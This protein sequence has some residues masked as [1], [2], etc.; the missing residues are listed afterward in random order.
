MKLSEN[1]TDACINTGFFPGCIPEIFVFGNDL[2]VDVSAGKAISDG[3]F[4]NDDQ[5]KPLEYGSD[6]YK[7]I[8]RIMAKEFASVY[9]AE[10]KEHVENSKK[11]KKYV[12]TLSSDTEKGAERLDYYKNVLLRN[13]IDLDE[14]MN[15]KEFIVIGQEG[16]GFGMKTRV[17]E[18]YDD[19]IT[20]ITRGEN[21]E[22]I[23]DE[24]NRS[25]LDVGVVDMTGKGYSNNTKTGEKVVVAGKSRDVYNDQV[26]NS[27]ASG[28]YDVI[29]GNHRGHFG[30]N[31]FDFE[32]NVQNITN[33]NQKQYLVEKY[34]NGT[35]SFNDIDN[36]Y[37]G[38]N[39][40]MVDLRSVSSI[41]RNGNVIPH[42]QTNLNN[43][44]GYNG[45][46]GNLGCPVVYGN[47]FKQIQRRFNN[48]VYH[49]NQSGKLG[50]FYIYQ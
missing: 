34:N 31:L 4:G 6:E 9:E 5:A 24:A 15:E 39:G 30:F 1:Y 36:E 47:D 28:E 38:A 7:K 14:V 22:Y 33:E 23:I 13:D 46:F 21:G 12:N 20:Y 44:Q 10:D 45:Y 18:S 35:L 32:G 42:S 37:K 3:L 48:Q 19:R 29:Q 50:K 27:V 26:Q 49:G 41:D 8:Q 25:S 16:K 40:R 17:G 11:N 2:K 43:H